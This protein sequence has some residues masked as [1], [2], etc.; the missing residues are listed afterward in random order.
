MPRMTKRAAD[1]EEVSA[2]RSRKAS[3]G[4]SVLDLFARGHLD[5]F[6]EIA[7]ERG[8]ISWGSETR[9]LLLSGA[10]SAENRAEA[11]SKLGRAEREVRSLR[12]FAAAERAYEARLDQ[13]FQDYQD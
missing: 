2:K 3:S 12:S 5:R 7:S 8:L 13:Q 10:L 4:A 9:A 6:D 11:S 1:L